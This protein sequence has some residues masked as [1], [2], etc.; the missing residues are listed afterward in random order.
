LEV[1]ASPQSPIVNSMWL[2]Q[3]PY[4]IGFEQI[5]FSLLSKSDVVAHSVIIT[6]IAGVVIIGIAFRNFLNKADSARKRLSE[7]RKKYLR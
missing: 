6:L 5:Y 4:A 7:L 2:I 1:D 3:M